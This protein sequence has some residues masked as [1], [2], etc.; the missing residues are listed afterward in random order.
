MVTIKMVFLSKII[1]TTYLFM[2][3]ENQSLKVKED[4]NS[5][6]KWINTAELDTAVTEEEMKV[7]YFKM[8]EK[9]RL[10]KNEKRS[11]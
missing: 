2:A 11:L 4:E 9:A 6:V 7:Y 5:D 10:L 8:I 3:P 1:N